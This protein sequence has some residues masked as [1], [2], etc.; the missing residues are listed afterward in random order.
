LRPDEKPI[1][2]SIEPQPRE[3]VLR[4]LAAMNMAEDALSERAS[5][6]PSGASA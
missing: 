2:V 3:I 5:L 1:T 6:R 4:I